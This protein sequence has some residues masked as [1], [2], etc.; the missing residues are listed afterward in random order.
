[1]KPTALGSALMFFVL[2]HGRLQGG[3]SAQKLKIIEGKFS[4]L[5]M[6]AN[7]EHASKGAHEKPRQTSET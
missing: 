6:L 3:Q 1:M 7:D 4:L 2:L 5:F